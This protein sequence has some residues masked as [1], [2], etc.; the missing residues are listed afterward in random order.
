MKKP[1]RHSCLFQL[2]CGVASLLAILIATPP[3]AAATPAEV[4]EAIKQAKAYLYKQ[5]K[6]DNWELVAKPTIEDKGGNASVTAWQYG[7][8]TATAVYGL[9]SAGENPKKDARLK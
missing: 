1:A 7:G 8:V 3:A 4:D 6:G 5:M 2:L 9:L